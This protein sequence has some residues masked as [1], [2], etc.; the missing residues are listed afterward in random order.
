L[1]NFPPKRYGYDVLVV[2]RGYAPLYDVHLFDRGE[3]GL[4]VGDLA[5][6]REPLFYDDS[7]AVVAG[8]RQR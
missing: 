1:L 7:S 6:G 5:V 4:F 3:T 8:L 2:R